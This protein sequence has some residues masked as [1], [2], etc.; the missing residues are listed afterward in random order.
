MPERRLTQLA[1]KVMLEVC[2]DGFNERTLKV[3]SG[4]AVY[5]VFRE[6]LRVADLVS[7]PHRH[8]GKSY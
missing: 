1:P 8:S 7:L 3:R 2:G 5:F 6:D 4:S